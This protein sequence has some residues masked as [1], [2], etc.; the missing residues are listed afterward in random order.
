MLSELKRLRVETRTRTAINVLPPSDWHVSLSYCH[1]YQPP[2]CNHTSSRIDCN[3]SWTVCL[4]S[5]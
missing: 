4:S 2:D 5:S 1:K 3:I